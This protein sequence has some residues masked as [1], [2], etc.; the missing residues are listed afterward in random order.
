MDLHDSL[1]HEKDLLS[2]EYEMIKNRLRYA[3]E[4]RIAVKADGNF[5]KWFHVFQAL[6]RT[7]RKYI[8]RSE[9]EFAKL[10]L[11]KALD[12]QSLLDIDRKQRAIENCL[13]AYDPASS[14][15]ARFL[16]DHPA[17]NDLYLSDVKGL[18]PEV[19]DWAA[20]DYPCNPFRREAL[21][22][23]TD[24]GELV[25]SK[26]EVMIANALFSRGIPYRYECLL[27]LPDACYPD[28]TILH[29]RSQ[30]TLVWEHFGMMDNEQ[31]ADNAHHKLCQYTLHGWVPG[32]N[33]ITTYETLEHPLDSRQINAA[34]EYY[35]L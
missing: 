10:L 1:K 7:C 20:G 32:S 29:P 5:Q 6:G 23:S 11:Q 15:M 19:S 25:R 26:S 8:R 34:I 17:L 28:F 33:L 9:K 4:G 16:K 22:F 3:P 12:E 31:Y 24:R 21:I 13:E 30:S 35:L 18:D 2:Q 14:Y 27:P